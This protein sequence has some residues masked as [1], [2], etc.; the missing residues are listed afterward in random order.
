MNDLSSREKARAVARWLDDKQGENLAALDVAGISSVTDVIVVASARGVKHAQALAD[1]VLEQARRANREFLSMEGYKSGD[2]ILVDLN[3]VVVHIFLKDI[4]S[5]Y[6][7]E[8][9]WSEAK[10]L[11]LDGLGD[12]PEPAGTEEGE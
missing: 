9:M 10:R 8:G 11:D 5:F 6:N 3:D 12:A 4:R 7:I 2:W 1:N